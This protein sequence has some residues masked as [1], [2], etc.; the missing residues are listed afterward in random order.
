MQYLILL[1]MKGL[2]FSGDFLDNDGLLAI[3]S[4]VCNIEDLKICVW[5]GVETF[6]KGIPRD[7]IQALCKGV[8]SRNRPVSAGIS[9]EE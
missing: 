3:A 7:G 2:K 1:Q 8:L 5:C 9:V 6:S 4:C